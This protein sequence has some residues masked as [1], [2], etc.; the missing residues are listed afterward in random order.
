MR[1]YEHLTP[2][3]IEDI[4]N[5]LE[6][7]A[8][9]SA[10]LTVADI[11]E[12]LGIALDR[13]D[14]TGMNTYSATRLAGF[15]VMTYRQELAKTT[16]ARILEK[17]RTVEPEHLQNIEQPEQTIHVAPDY[18]TPDDVKQAAEDHVR[19]MALRTVTV[20]ENAT[21]PRP[22]NHA[23]LYN[24]ARTALRD[25]RCTLSHTVEHCPAV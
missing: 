4:E 18:M 8:R 3:G 5:A 1:H 22:E 16:E 13:A 20:I 10:G 23:R 19:H 25:G 12:A 14:R 2:Q 6:R 21:N 11:P 17:I 7:M 15:A 9:Q 24:G